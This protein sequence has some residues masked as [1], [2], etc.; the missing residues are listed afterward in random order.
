[1][2]DVVQAQ[3]KSPDAV[4]HAH[5]EERPLVHALPDAEG[6][7]RVPHQRVVDVDPERQPG[8]RPVSSAS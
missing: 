4:A 7:D 2:L 5:E 6:H 3:S 1:M 8:G